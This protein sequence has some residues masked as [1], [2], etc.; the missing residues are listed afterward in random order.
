MEQLA[1]SEQVN[2]LGQIMKYSIAQLLNGRYT[3][4][5]I[6]DHIEKIL[7]QKGMEGIC[8]GRFLPGGYAMPRRQEIAAC[9]NR[10]RKMI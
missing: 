7:N 9:I 6:V 8:G 2:L 3:M 10:Y 1:D 4:T 5:Q